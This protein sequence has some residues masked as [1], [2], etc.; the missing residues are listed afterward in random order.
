VYIENYRVIADKDHS[1]QYDDDKIQ[2][3]ESHEHVKAVEPD[4][5]MKT[6]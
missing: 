4:G 1:V 2:T 3:L 5:V 6:Q